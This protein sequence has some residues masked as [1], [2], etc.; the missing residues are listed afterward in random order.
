MADFNHRGS[1]LES[2]YNTNYNALD[3]LQQDQYS[4][5]NPFDSTSLDRASASFKVKDLKF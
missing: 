2:S 4:E 1:V 5:S 3:V